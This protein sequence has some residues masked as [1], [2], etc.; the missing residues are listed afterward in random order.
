M[1]ETPDKASMAELLAAKKG[2]DSMP[3]T[4]AESEEAMVTTLRSIQERIQRLSER[5]APQGETYKVKL[6]KIEADF[7]N[8]VMG[9]FKGAGQW[10]IALN[11]ID[12][13]V[14]LWNGKDTTFVVGTLAIGTL[15]SVIAGIA[16]GIQ[17]IKKEISISSLNR[18]T[19]E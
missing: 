3:V 7:A 8:A 9:Y 6:D 17:K 4:V 15:F 5:P 1:S 11:V 12:S 18:N 10:A 19:V 2:I 16:T 14:N 13:V